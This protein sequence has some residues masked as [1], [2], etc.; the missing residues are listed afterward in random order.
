MPLQPNGLA[1]AIEAALPQAWQDV[2]HES[3]P[4]TDPTERRPLFLAIARGLLQYLH[5]HQGDMINAMDL[6]VGSGVPVRHTASDLDLNIT[7]LPTP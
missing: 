4:A 2:K 5:D 1:D 3:L 6:R 7:G